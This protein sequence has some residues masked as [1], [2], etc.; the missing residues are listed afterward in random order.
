MAKGWRGEC[1]ISDEGVE[2]LGWIEALPREARREL[3][4]T[5]EMLCRAQGYIS[6]N[7]EIVTLDEE[8]RQRLPLPLRARRPR[9]DAPLAQVIRHPRWSTPDE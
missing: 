4:A 3:A 2:V 8:R 7:D 6:L 5:V 1:G 9:R